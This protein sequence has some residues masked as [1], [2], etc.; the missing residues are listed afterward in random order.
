MYI[1]LV[2]IH[3]IDDKSRVQNGSRATCTWGLCV[4]ILIMVYFIIVTISVFIL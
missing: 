4:C 2:K 1:Q 3:F